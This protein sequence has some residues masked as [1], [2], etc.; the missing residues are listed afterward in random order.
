[1]SKQQNSPCNVSTAEFLK[2]IHGDDAKIY[3]N[4][5]GKTWKDKPQPYSQA[6]NKLRWLNSDKD[7]DIC[8]IVNT[9]GTTNATITRVNAAFLD[10][11][12]GKNSDGN[13]LPLHEVAERKVEFLANVEH[14]PL[15]PTFIVETRNGYHIY[16]L[17]H[18]GTTNEQLVEVQHRIAFYFGGDSS[19]AKPAQVMRL[20]G[21]D[22]VKPE[23]NCDRFRVNTFQHNNVRYSINDLMSCFPVVSETDWKTYKTCEKKADQ[24]ISVQVNTT[25]IIPF[26][27]NAIILDTYPSSIDNVVVLNNMEEA[28]Q[29]IKA[30]NPA[31]Y[32][33]VENYAN[34][35]KYVISCPFHNDLTPSAQVYK[36]YKN[37][38]YYVKCYSK[39]CS[40]ELGTIIEV[41]MQQEQCSTSEAIQILMS[42]YNITLDD[43]WKELYRQALEANVSCIQS[44]DDNRLQ[45]PYLHKCIYRVKGDL[46]TKQTIAKEHVSL[47][48]TTG[49]PMF[50]CSLEKFHQASTGLYYVHGIGRQNERIDRYCLLGLMR[51]LPDAEINSSLLANAYNVRDTI[52]KVH[53]M[54]KKTVNM[55]RTQFYTIPPYTDEVLKAADDICKIL[56]ERGVRLNAISRDVIVRVFGSKKGEEVYPQVH[57]TTISEGGSKFEAKVE[58]ELLSGV[59]QR[60]YCRVADIVSEL[61]KQHKW[62]TV[63]D[64]RVKK[65]IPG[66]LMKHGLTEVCAT[67]AVKEKYQIAAKGYPRIIVAKATDETVLVNECV[68]AVP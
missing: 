49:E 60:G 17:L 2:Q 56:T 16:W 31:R 42:F 51:K 43:S 6:E 38:Y 37:G 61:Q 47:Q 62:K 11:D 46:L 27:D 23:K 30:Q 14:S 21:Y 12:C 13:Y 55:C 20:P 29:Y 28:V 40:F 8:F 36:F 41:V 10:W 7:K 26:K 68:V 45:Y 33:N 58:A 44:I 22:W 1:M 59:K 18:A 67:K 52:A 34:K 9:G 15:K 32:L 54:N 24:T 63:T 35:E 19:V 65:Y 64:R 48:S 25:S 57:S 50:I 39:E 4:V 66:L 3:F 53:S 5:G